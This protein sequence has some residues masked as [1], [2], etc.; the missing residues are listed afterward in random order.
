MDKVYIDNIYIGAYLNNKKE[1]SKRHEKHQ[2]NQDLVIQP[3][4]YNMYYC[5]SQFMEQDYTATRGR[6]AFCILTLLQYRKKK[7]SASL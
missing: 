5:V 6:S 2:Q 3:E 1:K 4:G 7:K